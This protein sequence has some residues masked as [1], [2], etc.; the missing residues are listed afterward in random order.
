[1]TLLY[2]F[3]AAGFNAVMD[4]LENENFHASVF[5][6]SDQKFWYKRES[7]KHAKKIFGYKIDGWHI[8]KSIMICTILIPLSETFLQWVIYGL[9]WNVVF[10]ITYKLLKTT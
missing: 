3:L 2:I 4:I 10:G 5:S 1:M 9:I 6:K 8:S 7:W